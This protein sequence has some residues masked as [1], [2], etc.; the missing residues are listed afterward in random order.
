MM[1]NLYLKTLATGAGIKTSFRVIYRPLFIYLTWRPESL[2]ALNYISKHLFNCWTLHVITE[3]FE[4][5]P[6]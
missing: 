2:P 4:N 5:F 6:D 3:D 1:L